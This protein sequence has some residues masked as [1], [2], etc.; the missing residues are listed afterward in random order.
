MAEPIPVRDTFVD[1]CDRIAYLAQLQA[2]AN[3]SIRDASQVSMGIYQSLGE[4]V[5]GAIDYSATVA[6]DVE[7]QLRRAY[8]AAISYSTRI[9][10]VIK[11]ALVGV[12]VES[13]SVAQ[14]TA[15]DIQDTASQHGIRVTTPYDVA[16]TGPMPSP[17][18]LLAVPHPGMPGGTIYPRMPGDGSPAGGAGDG[19]TARSQAAYR[20]ALQILADKL[21]VRPALNSYRARQAA[22]NPQGESRLRLQIYRPPEQD[23]GS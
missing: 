23:K 16:A 17:G 3:D 21:R 11:Q 6:D 2:R 14:Q 8:T 22:A 7:S 15:R 18:Q 1:E 19:D 9:I 10:N 13:M 12:I 5:Q 4:Q 20:K